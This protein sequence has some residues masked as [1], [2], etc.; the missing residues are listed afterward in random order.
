M[1]IIKNKR[2]KPENILKEYPNAEIFDVTSMD[3]TK[4]KLKGDRPRG[5]SQG[6]L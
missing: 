2:T 6:V 5:N 4:R 3:F 1:I